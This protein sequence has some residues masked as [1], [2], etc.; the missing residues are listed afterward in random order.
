MHE[1]RPGPMLSAQSVFYV[2][3]K[4]GMPYCHAIALYLDMHS[5]VYRQGWWRPHQRQGRGLSSAA[6]GNESRVRQLSLALC[7]VQSSGPIQQPTREPSGKHAQISPG[8]C[9]CM[10][11]CHALLTDEVRC[12]LC[13]CQPLQEFAVVP[14]SLS[15]RVG[16]AD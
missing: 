2:L 16:F 1:S 11:V 4:V 13:I 5:C 3:C 10:C 14:D 9:A 8:L 7:W 12:L 15:S 6:R